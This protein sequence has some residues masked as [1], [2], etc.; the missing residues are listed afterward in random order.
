MLADLEEV[1]NAVLDMDAFNREIDV[2][3]EEVEYLSTVRDM[4]NDA[5]RGVIRDLNEPEEDDYSDHE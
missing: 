3:N 2:R 4:T 5:L 1:I